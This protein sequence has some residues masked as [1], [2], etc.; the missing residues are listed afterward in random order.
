MCF[1]LITRSK[2][3]LEQASRHS[4]YW[5]TIILCHSPFLPTTRYISF[6]RVSV[7]PEWTASVGSFH[8]PFESSGLFF[9]IDSATSN[10]QTTPHCKPILPST[11]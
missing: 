11:S 1:G 3:T 10:V 7:S 2:S 6:E 5:F 4:V 9:P 8:Y